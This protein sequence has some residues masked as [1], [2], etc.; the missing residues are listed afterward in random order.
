MQ[1]GNQRHA[2]TAK[3]H[4][5]PCDDSAS[6]GQLANSALRGTQREGKTDDAG[7]S[8]QEAHLPVR[9]QAP[10]RSFHARKR[11]C[12]ALPAQVGGQAANN[13]LSSGGKAPKA[14]VAWLPALVPNPGM[15]LD[16]TQTRDVDNDDGPAKAS[17]AVERLLR[18]VGLLRHLVW[19]SPLA[20]KAVLTSEAFQAVRR[21]WN[22]A[23]SLEGDRR[24]LHELFKLLDNCVCADAAA[25]DWVVSQTDDKSVL[26][27]ITRLLR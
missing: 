18:D 10:G 1:N 9:M 2:T 22:C 13:A 8:S 3:L 20:S 14:A 17:E 24:I 25:A 19:R 21:I 5:G 6:D 11:R 4:S 15:H 23:L 12:N 27:S 7:C 26:N 16:A